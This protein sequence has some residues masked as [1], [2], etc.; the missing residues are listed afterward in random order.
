MADSEN[1]R[2]GS[3]GYHAS[4]APPSPRPSVASRPSRSS[5]RRDQELPAQ[6]RPASGVYSRPH[7]PQYPAAGPIEEPPALSSPP[8]VQPTP[9]PPFSPLFTLLASTSHPSNRQTIQ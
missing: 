9:P 4:P 1:D 8:L 3:R 7:T 6:P 2:P 5:L